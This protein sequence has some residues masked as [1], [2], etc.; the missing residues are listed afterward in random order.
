[1]KTLESNISYD[2]IDIF[3]HNSKSLAHLKNVHTQK[4]EA[5]NIINLEFLGMLDETQLI[6]KTLRDVD[7]FMQEYWGN[8]LVDSIED[9]EKLVLKHNK[10]ISKKRNIM[11]N[12][13]NKLAVLNIIKFPVTNDKNIT[14]SILT[15][16][17]DVTN[18]TCPAVIYRSYR[19]FKQPNLAIANF[20][21]H[22]EIQ[23]YFDS[24]PSEP[25][26]LALIDFANRSRQVSKH[27]KQI[28]WDRIESLENK[29]CRSSI[30]NITQKIN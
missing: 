4:Y 21:K 1:M 15:I 16:S 12:R 8:R 26:L 2:T 3:I 22:F 17:E 6:G 14:K 23:E 11:F 24:I 30:Q 9:I 25:E 13:R 7:K 27:D 19:I 5:T 29:I 28:D 20:L 18:N 10:P